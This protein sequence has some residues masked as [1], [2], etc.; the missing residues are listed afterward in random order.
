MNSLLV[1]VMVV[2]L[3]VG[4]STELL[5]DGPFRR[6]VCQPT[7][8]VSSSSVHHDSTAIKIIDDSA[9]VLAE[10]DLLGQSYSAAPIIVQNN[11]AA[12]PAGLGTTVYGYSAA[13]LGKNAAP[14]RVDPTAIMREAARQTE[15][16]QQ[17]MRESVS[18]YRTLGTDAIGLAAL[19]E[20]TAQLR[21]RAELISATEPAEFVQQAPAPAAVQRL[22]SGSQ[23]ICITPDGSGGF[24]I[25][26]EGAPAVAPETPATAPPNDAAS[27]VPNAVKILH[28]HCAACHTGSAAKGGVELFADSATFIEPDQATAARVLESVRSG[29][30]PEGING[31]QPA[32]LTDRELAELTIYLQGG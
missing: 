11:F 7:R 15:L 26:F 6:N 4:G 23:T 16:S 29:S 5:A 22:Q 13:P 21:A 31:A 1:R 30:M 17:L 9:I 27:D 3:L 18:V 12:P 28:Q 19:Q 2:G 32:T 14:Y 8:I 24:R 10:A 25:H 20:Q